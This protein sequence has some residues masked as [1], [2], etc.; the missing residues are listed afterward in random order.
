MIISKLPLIGLL[1]ENAP[2]PSV[3]LLEQKNLSPSTGILTS[4]LDLAA[5]CSGQLMT[6]QFGAYATDAKMS[7]GKKGERL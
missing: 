5:L 2:K 1:S 4:K 3:T 6:G 7:S